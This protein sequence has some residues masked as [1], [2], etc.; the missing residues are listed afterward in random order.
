MLNTLA[1]SDIYS[2]LLLFP[3]VDTGALLTFGWGLHG[4]VNIL[5]VTLL[6]FLLVSEKNGENGELSKIGPPYVYISENMRSY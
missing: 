4:Q 1:Y 5:N 3:T 6:F 2:P